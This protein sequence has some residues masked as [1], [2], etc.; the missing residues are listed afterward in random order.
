M[1]LEIV[2][3]YCHL[4]HIVSSSLGDKQDILSRRNAFIEQDTVFCVTL[5]NC[6]GP[7]VCFIL[8]V[9]V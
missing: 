7:A 4:G 3:S 2:S 6:L 5:G 8:F 9:S 1:R